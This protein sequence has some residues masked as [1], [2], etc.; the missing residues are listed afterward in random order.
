MYLV[1]DTTSAVKRKKD[2][3]EDES[4]LAKKAR[5]VA[6]VANS[7]NIKNESQNSRQQ[8]DATLNSNQMKKQS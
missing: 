8:N 7:N 4:E 5:V 6:K 1:T 3:P 2:K